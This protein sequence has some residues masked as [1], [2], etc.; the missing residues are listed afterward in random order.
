[1]RIIPESELI[2]N[3][4]GSIFHLHIRP[5]QLAGNVILVG[6]PGRVE[7]VASHFDSVECG[8]SSREFKFMTGSYKGTGFTVLSTGIGTDNIDIVMNELDALVNVD[9]KTRQVKEK[10]TVLNIL[11][12][13]TCGAVQPDIPLGAYIFSH[14]SIGADGLMNWYAGR[15]EVSIPDMEKAFMEHMDYDRN[16]GRP[17]FIEADR[18]LI[19]AFADCSLKG[20]TVA[21]QGFYGPQGRYVRIPLAMP[22]MVEKF[23]S[24][25]YNG[26]RITNF[27]MEGS[28]LAALSRKL[29][30]RAG[31][32]CL[33]IAN[34]H[35]KGVNPDYKEL[36]DKL[37]CIVLD[38]LVT[39]K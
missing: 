8:G 10:L 21:A 28:A 12:I 11:R 34:R 30:H 38:R 22:D 19:D 37:V 39:F 29:G 5:E 4:D 31:T 24:F 36:M 14:I 1:M 25:S 20:M 17:Y 32:I 15:D 23:T 35:F 18:K 2:I 26:Y 3:S 33:A 7:M 27:E 6:D 9:F 16:L 13:G